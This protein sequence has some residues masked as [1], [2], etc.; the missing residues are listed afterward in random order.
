MQRIGVMQGTALG[1]YINRTCAFWNYAPP[2]NCG[3]CTTGLNVGASEAADKAVSDV[4]ETCWAARQESG[5]TFVHLNAGYQGS[6]GISLALPYVSAIKEHVGMLVGA[7]LAPE[8]DFSRYDALID[9]GVD[10]LS[11]CLEFMDADWFARMCP[12]KAVVLGQHLFLDAME[13][14]AARMPK[15]AV[16]G[17]IIAG[18]EPIASTMA[19][20]DRITDLGAFPTVCIFRPTIGSNLES[21]PSPSYEDMRRVMAYAYDA[22]RRHWI[23]LGAAPNIETSLVVNPDDAAMLAPRTAG[24]YCYEAFRAATKVVSRPVFHRRLQPRATVSPALS[25]GG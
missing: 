21:Q 23:P 22:C 24:Y 8:R 14:C 9:A 16:S 3:F 25:Y 18:L 1:I 17:E 20:I 5:A 7:Q 10:H 15:G 11:F 4:I 12:G 13:Y 19:A 6:R 2:L